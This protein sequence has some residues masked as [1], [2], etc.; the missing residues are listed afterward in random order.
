MIF[1]SLILFAAINFQD[2]EPLEFLA[3]AA[4]AQRPSESTTTPLNIEGFQLD[5]NLRERGDQRNDLDIQLDYQQADGGTIKLRL[6]DPNRGVSVS[7]GFDGKRYWLKEHNGELIN[8]AAREFTQDREAIDQAL[9]LCER[10]RLIFDLRYL[11]TQ[12]QELSLEEQDQ[13]TIIRGKFPAQGLVHHLELIFNSKTLQLE[14][15]FIKVP[16]AKELDGEDTD[17]AI[18]TDNKP[19]WQSQTRFELS[20]YRDFAGL[21]APQLIHQF[22][23]DRKMPT[24]IVE[25]HQLKWQSADQRR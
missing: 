22:I 17:A 13:Q 2:S 25:I 12:C 23:P 24:R 6:D 3:L 21:M 5:I 20:Y 16:K 10:L 19:E 15:L 4:E 9:E 11:G 14:Q 8:L 18:T 1:S 7:K